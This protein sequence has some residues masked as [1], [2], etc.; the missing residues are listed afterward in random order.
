MAIEL[1]ATVLR[2]LTKELVDLQSSPCEGIRVQLNEHELTD[3]QAEIDGPTGTP[4]EGGLFRIKLV[5]ACPH[6]ALANTASSRLPSCHT[7]RPWHAAFMPWQ[8][9]RAQQP[10]S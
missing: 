8:R 10:C 4:F 3:V 9:Q 5:C 6:M 2:R 7:V 1:S